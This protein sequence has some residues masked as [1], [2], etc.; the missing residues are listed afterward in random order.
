MD[1]STHRPQNGQTLVSMVR[2]RPQELHVLVG[3]SSAAAGASASSLPQSPQNFFPSGFSEPQFLHFIGI[4]L[5]LGMF[6]HLYG[7]CHGAVFRICPKGN[8]HL[9]YPCFVAGGCSL[10]RKKLSVPRGSLQLL[11]PFWIREGTGQDGQGL[12][13]RVL[14]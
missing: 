8:I 2:V 13:E 14:R 6:V 9:S 7:F 5:R 4:P 1:R 10:E 12:C 3:F 11:R